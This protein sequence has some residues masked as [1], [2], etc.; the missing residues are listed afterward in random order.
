MLFDLL[1]L[2]FSLKYDND[3]EK[4]RLTKWVKITGIFN[5]KM[6]SDRRY[7]LVQQKYELPLSSPR[8]VNRWPAEENIAVFLPWSGNWKLRS[9][10]FVYLSRGG[11]GPETLHTGNFNAALDSS[12]QA[13]EARKNCVAISAFLVC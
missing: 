5:L 11:N 10:R 8:L 9:D 3:H 2:S 7:A 4:K 1:S 6:S 12:R 13:N